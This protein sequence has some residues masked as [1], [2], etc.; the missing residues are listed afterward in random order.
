MRRNVCSL[1]A[2]ACLLGTSVS[3]HAG[4]MTTGERQRVLAHLEMSEGWLVSEAEGLSK[5]QLTF[6]M[7]PESW[8]I[9]DVVEHLAIAEPQV[10]GSKCKTR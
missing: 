3:T 10:P 9:E 7:T 6:R 2:L 5:A 4:P 8:S 1:V